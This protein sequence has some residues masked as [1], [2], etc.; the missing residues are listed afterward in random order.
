[1]AATGVTAF[2]V[3]DDERLAAQFSHMARANPKF[4]V[5]TE[6][7]DVVGDSNRAPPA[8]AACNGTVTIQT[9]GADT[10]IIVSLLH[11]ALEQL[12]ASGWVTSSC[13]LVQRPNLG[14]GADDPRRE[15][16]TGV[17]FGAIGE[18]A[19]SRGSTW[20]LVVRAPS[21]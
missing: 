10:G 17:A 13:Q 4:R 11:E 1:M 8:V 3:S 19:R 20:R 9:L 6:P 12:Q 14:L 5:G 2:E 18:M 21:E 7:A 16:V 15:N